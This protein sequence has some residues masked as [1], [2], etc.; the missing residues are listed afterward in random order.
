MAYVTVSQVK[1]MTGVTISSSGIIKAQTI[2][3]MFSNRTEAEGADVSDRDLYWLRLATAYQAAYMD[4]HPELYE[5]MNVNVLIQGDLH[6]N[7]KQDRRNM[8]V[9]P[10]ADVALKNISWMRSRSI[11]MNSPF[12][13]GSVESD[14][15]ATD[16]DED[17][18]NL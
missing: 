13:H 2:I 16:D 4:S 8:L 15:L 14:T 18:S 5:L 6:V 9:A 1:D 17:W 3:E 11:S 12:Q 7:F 10:M